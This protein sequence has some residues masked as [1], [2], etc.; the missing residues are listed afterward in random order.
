MLHDEQLDIAVLQA[1]HVLLDELRINPAQHKLQVLE[2]EDTYYRQ[3]ITFYQTIYQHWLLD[4][5][6]PD[7][8]QL[9]RLFWF[10]LH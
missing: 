1:T 4:N 9:Q 6:Q 5:V 3:L 10:K 7:A 2:L 8:H